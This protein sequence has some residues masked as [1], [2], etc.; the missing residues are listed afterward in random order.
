MVLAMAA[1]VTKFLS[2]PRAGVEHKQTEEKSCLA[3]KERNNV[4]KLLKLSSVQIL[5]YRFSKDSLPLKSEY[6]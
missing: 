4:S 5:T 6:Y 1:A 3:L 2:F